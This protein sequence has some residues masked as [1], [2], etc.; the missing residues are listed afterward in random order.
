MEF[1][2]EPGYPLAVK[3]KTEGSNIM[4]IPLDRE[5]ISVEIIDGWVSYRYGVKQRAP[6][7]KYSQN[8]AVPCSF[9]NII[10]PYQGEVEV[11]KVVSVMSEVVDKIFTN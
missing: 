7:V 4:I 9:C 8:S 1:E 5:G 2:F 3:T 10:Y 6:I 11:D